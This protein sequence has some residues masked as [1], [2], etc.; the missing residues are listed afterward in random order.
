MVTISDWQGKF[1]G[2][3]EGHTECI[4]SPIKTALDL[5]QQK[6][7]EVKLISQFEGF[8]ALLGV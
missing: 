2:F 5:V 3:Y 1:A 8:I 7:G 6:G 4:A